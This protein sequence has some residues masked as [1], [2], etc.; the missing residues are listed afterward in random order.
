[1]FVVYKNLTLKLIKKYSAVLN[2]ERNK[3]P[4]VLKRVSTVVKPMPTENFELL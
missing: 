3:K 4:V 2:K 1:M